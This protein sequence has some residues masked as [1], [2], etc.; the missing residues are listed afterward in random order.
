MCCD[1]KAIVGRL[2][3]FCNKLSHII[4]RVVLGIGRCIEKA[5]K[6]IRSSELEVK[7][8]RLYGFG[9]KNLNWQII[10]FSS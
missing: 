10:H 5:A 6:K 4:K 9:G 2:G 8:I 3:I 7:P 1:I